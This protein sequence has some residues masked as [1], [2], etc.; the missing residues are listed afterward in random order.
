MWKFLRARQNCTCNVTRYRWCT[1][2]FL[3]QLAVI[4]SETRL[5]R[6]WILWPEGFRFWLRNS[7]QDYIRRA[8]LSFVY[9][10]GYIVSR[11]CWQITFRSLSEAGKGLKRR[12]NKQKS[13]GWKAEH[14]KISRSPA[15]CAT[16]YI[17]VS[18]RCFADGN[19][20]YPKMECWM[21]R[22]SEQR[23]TWTKKNE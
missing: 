20:M 1:Q 19:C 18:R 22:Q 5:K 10:H 3:Q 13:G 15:Q 9:L 17:C 14:Y 16:V 23:Q 8:F 7:S 2:D 11:R 21:Y 6:W 12:I 4:S